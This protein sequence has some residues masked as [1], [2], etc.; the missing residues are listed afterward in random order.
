MFERALDPTAQVLSLFTVIVKA[1]A[2]CVQL[3]ARRRVQ[4]ELLPSVQRH[5][6]RL[7]EI[8]ELERDRIDG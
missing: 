8:L 7:R 3:A 5:H 1:R 4:Q 2:M 6:L